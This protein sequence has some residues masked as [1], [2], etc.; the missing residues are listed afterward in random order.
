[1]LDEEGGPFGVGTLV[2]LGDVRANPSRPESEDHLFATASARDLRKLDPNEY[3]QLLDEVAEDDLESIFGPDLERR[4]RSFA[5]EEGRGRVSLGVLRVQ[6]TPDLEIDDWGKLRL[7]LDYVDDP[8]RLGVTDLRFVEADHRTLKQ[9]AIRDAQ[10]RMRNG[11]D[12]LLM[13]GLARAF[14][15]TGDDRRRHWLQVNGICME[16]RPLGHTP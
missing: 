7:T 5:I 6:E 10:Q 9:D 15:A 2:D 16:D 13:V 11:V 14:V 1:M 12:L 3:W 8:A 4:G